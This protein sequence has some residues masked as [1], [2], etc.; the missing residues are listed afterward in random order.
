MYSVPMTTLPGEPAGTRVERDSLGEVEVPAGA[1]YGAHTVRAVTNFRV[2]GVTLA[3]IACSWLAVRMKT[4]RG[5]SGDVEALYAYLLERTE[6]VQGER[7][8]REF[9]N[10]IAASRAGWRAFVYPEPV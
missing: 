8:A 9:A 1:L 5:L 6:K 3:A 7:R 10:L 4:A 2:S